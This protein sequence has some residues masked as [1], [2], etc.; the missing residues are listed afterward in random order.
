MGGLIQARD[1]AIPSTLNSLNT[2][3]YNLA[4]AVNTQNMAGYDLSGT[5]GGDFFAPLSG[6]AGAASNISVAITDPTKI[7]ASSDGT[8]GSNGN[9]VLLAG[10]QNQSIVSGQTVTDYYANMVNNVANQVSF[11]NN[12]QQSGTALMQQL[13]NQLTSISGVSIDQEAANLV[14]YQQAYDA[15]AQVASAI[16]Q[17]ITTTI[18]MA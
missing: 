7:A 6:V 18:N 13:Q 11:A 2:L 9:A 14:L 8:A 3:A 1:T 12:Q 10:I 16:N 15:S 5:A 4:T 17:L